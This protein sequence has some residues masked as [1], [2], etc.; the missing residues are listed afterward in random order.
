MI[1]H[2]YIAITLT[3]FLTASIFGNDRT[4][5]RLVTKTLQSLDIDVSTVRVSHNKSKGGK[6]TIIIVYTISDS[7]S[8]ELAELFKI[9]ESGYAANMNS[10]ADLDVIM[11]VVG[12]KYGKTI[13]TFCVYCSYTKKYINSENDIS[14]TI[15]YLEKWIVVLDNRYYFKDVAKL[16]GW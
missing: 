4:I 11:V 3:I 2:F 5:E 7:S 14:D 10:Y 6:R 1:K 12:D 15:D 9:L 13:G 8:R 16:M